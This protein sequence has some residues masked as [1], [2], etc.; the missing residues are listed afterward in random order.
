MSDPNNR[1]NFDSKI[2]ILTWGDIAQEDLYDVYNE[3]KLPRSGINITKLERFV[4]PVLTIRDR[5]H[6]KK[7]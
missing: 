3:P 1:Y 4:L 5:I 7:D 2:K 6:G